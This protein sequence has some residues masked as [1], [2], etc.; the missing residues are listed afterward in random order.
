MAIRLRTVGGIRVAL[1]AAE[2]DAIAGDLYLDDSDHYAL[3]AKFRHDWHGE[4]NS[5]TYP[6]EWAAMESQRVRDARGELERWLEA[7]G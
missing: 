2:T 3:A 7:R 1:C 6:D 5:V 4:V